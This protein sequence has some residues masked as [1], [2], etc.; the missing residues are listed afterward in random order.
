M[1]KI[2]NK[3]V[4]KNSIDK[5]R[6]WVQILAKYRTPNLYRSIFELII[7]FIPFILIWALAWYCLSYS[8][9]ITLILSAFNSLFILR[10]FVI[11]HDCGHSS[12]FKS[13]AVSDWVGRFIGVLT[14]TPYDVWRRTHSEHHSGAGNLGRQGMGDINTKTVS[15]YQALS[16]FQKF[17]YRLYRNPFVLFAIIPTYL[18]MLQN[19]LP[20]GLMNSGSKYWLSAMGTNLSIAI[21]LSTI[22]YFGGWA[23]VCLI[24]LPST[25]LAATF[26]VWLF[27]VQH[28]FEDTHWDHQEEWDMHEAALEGSSHYDLPLVLHWFSAN[29]GIHHI[30]HLYS[31]IPFYRLPQIVKDYP[32]LSEN[33]RLSIYESFAC[34]KLHLWDE[35]DRKLISYKQFHRKYGKV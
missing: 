9:W 34:V 33:Q 6:D 20:L 35:N 15:E 21:V 25:L 28:Q 24:F 32:V 1:N 8:V 22:Y 14:I 30:H 19:R 18:F 17:I 11:Q 2:F 29:I 23:P 16:Q 10:L 26:G 27:Y 12:F 4:N 31:R 13:R 7:T 5:A 3:E